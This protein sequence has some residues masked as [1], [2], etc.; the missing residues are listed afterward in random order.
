MQHQ[1]IDQLQ[2]IAEAGL[3]DVFVPMSRSQRLE[4]W[5][6]VLEREPR[7]ILTALPGTE[8]MSGE[9]REI[10][11]CLESPISVAFADPLLRLHGMQ[12]ETYGEA[13][14]FFE[15]SDRALHY[16]VCHCHV[17]AT[18]QAGRA[19]RCVRRAIDGDIFPRAG[20]I[21]RGWWHGMMTRGSTSA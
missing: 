8:H 20:A 13:K 18:M 14:R 17:G 7:R 5:A 6:E 9:S 3:N 12:S 21:V 4:R 2:I 19:A 1:S 11:R 15:L 16:I 10:A